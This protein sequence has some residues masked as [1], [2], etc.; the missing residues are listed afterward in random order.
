MELR[1]ENGL[2]ANG[3]LFNRM[4]GLFAE[5][6][7]P[8]RIT[9]AAD[10]IEEKESYHFYFEIPGL[11]NDSFDVRVENGNLII[12]AER[13]RPEWTSDARVHV[14]ERGYGRIH[15]AFELPEDASTEKVNASYKDGVLE[16]TVEK[17]PELKPVKI[18][19]N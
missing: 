6:N 19:I 10:V 11:K 7:T 3:W 17:R 4:N 13:K 8:Q 5:L 18:Q 16:I 2:P 12:S 1:Y 15:R 9:L 14:A